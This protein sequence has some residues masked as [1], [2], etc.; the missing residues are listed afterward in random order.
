MTVLI[1]TAT[2]SEPH[3][4]EETHYLCRWRIPIWTVLGLALTVCPILVL[5]WYCLDADWMP[6]T[7]DFSR[8]RRRGWVIAFIG[9][10]FFVLFM[11][12]P[13]WIR[14]PFLLWSSL[15]LLRLYI[16][17]IFQAFDREPDFVIS[18]AGVGGWDQTEF[19]FFPW[20]EVSNLTV[21]TNQQYFL[22]FKIVPAQQWIDIHGP[23]VGPR[24][25]FKTLP[26]RRVTL[27]YSQLYFPTKNAE[28]LRSIH[29]YRP[30]LVPNEYI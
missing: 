29:R 27:M 23:E 15:K 30:D 10:A 28:I 16:R 5:A 7:P 1:D 24:R 21:R 20:P 13:V 9:W 8:G 11:K 26:P 3:Y 4:Q 22:G 14:I 25:L 6:Q 19:R 18:P 12:L 17:W 2:S